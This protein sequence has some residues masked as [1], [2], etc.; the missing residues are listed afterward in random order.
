MDQLPPCVATVADIARSSCARQLCNHLRQIG[1]DVHATDARVVVE[2]LR[3][4][5]THNRADRHILR[6]PEEQRKFVRS[7]QYSL[8]SGMELAANKVKVL[9]KH[10]GRGQYVVIAKSLREMVPLTRWADRI[11]HRSVVF[12]LY[13]AAERACGDSTVPIERDFFSLIAKLGGHG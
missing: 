12:W 7:V 13:A 10:R 2:V 5:I 4:S 6:V 1:I 3:W 11:N 8:R 9:S